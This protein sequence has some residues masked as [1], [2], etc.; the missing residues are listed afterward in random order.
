MRRYLPAL[1]LL[2]WLLGGP[3]RAAGPPD[4]SG[5]PA[6]PDPVTVGIATLL[7]GSEAPVVDGER[8]DARMLRRLYEPRG[9]RALWLGEGDAAARGRAI[10]A[11]LD[12]ASTHGLDPAAHH[13]HAI[14]RPPGAAAPRAGGPPVAAPAGMAPLISIAPRRRGGPGGGSLRDEA[15]SEGRPVDPQ[16][17]AEA[18]AAAPDL[19][20]SLGGVPPASADYRGLLDALARYRAAAKA[21]GWPAIPTRGPTVTPGMSVP[22][23]L[24]VRQRLVA[25][26][27]PAGAD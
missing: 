11:A 16:G 18:A 2:P 6:A 20:A 19:S 4:A 24:L 9:Y 12:H 15:A 10:G 14:A 21:G 26:D 13:R 17:L 7:T 22:V 5:T 3:V 27:E 1:M 25:T 8:L 23:V